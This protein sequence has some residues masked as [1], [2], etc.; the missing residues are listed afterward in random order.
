MPNNRSAARAANGPA[1]YRLPEELYQE[2]LKQGTILHR[3]EATTAAV[4]RQEEK[5]TAY[6]VNTRGCFA[7]PCSSITCQ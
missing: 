2:F 1:P 6:A 3:G 7:P 4:L 5:I